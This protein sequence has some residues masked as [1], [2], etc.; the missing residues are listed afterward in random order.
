MV[1]EHGALPYGAMLL[2]HGALPYG[3]VVVDLKNN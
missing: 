2:K 3:A 1:S